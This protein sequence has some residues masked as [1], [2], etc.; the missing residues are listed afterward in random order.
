M[1]TGDQRAIRCLTRHFR[2]QLAVAPSAARFTM[3]SVSASRAVCV[4]GFQLGEIFDPRD[5]AQ[6]SGVFVQLGL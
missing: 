5:I 2:Y 3:A 6:H 4:F 1:A